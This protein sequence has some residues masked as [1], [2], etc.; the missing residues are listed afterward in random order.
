MP[1][2]AQGPLVL[3]DDGTLLTINGSVQVNFKS[4]AMI[5]A[6]RRL[7]SAFPNNKRVPI[8]DLTDHGSLARL[9][10]GKRWALLKPYINSINGLWGFNL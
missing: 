10:G 8:R 9:F 5:T 2:P 7:V 6:I 4:E 3:S 1:E